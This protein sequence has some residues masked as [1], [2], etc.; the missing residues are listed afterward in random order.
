M[1]DTARRVLLDAAADADRSAAHWAEVADRHERQAA[2]ARG[3]QLAVEQQ[4]AQIR[5]ELLAAQ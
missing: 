3:S 2:E 5:A 1:N 4:A